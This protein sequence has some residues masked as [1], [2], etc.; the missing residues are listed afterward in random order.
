PAGCGGPV[1]RGAENG[2]WWGGREA[3]SRVRAERLGGVGA[4][5]PALRGGQVRGGA[6]PRR[7]GARI[8]PSVRRDLLQRRMLREPRRTHRGRAPAPPPCDRAVRPL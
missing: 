8:R 3:G 2:G 4:V 5:P 7:G 1:P 6:G